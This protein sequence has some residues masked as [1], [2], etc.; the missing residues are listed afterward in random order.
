MVHTE[1]SKKK[2]RSLSYQLTDSSHVHHTETLWVNKNTQN[3]VPQNLRR[4]CKSGSNPDLDRLNPSLHLSPIR[5]CFTSEPS[6]H[7]DAFTNTLTLNGR[8][9]LSAPGCHGKPHGCPFPP[10]ILL[11]AS[12][13]WIPAGSSFFQQLS[14]ALCTRWGGIVWRGEDRLSLFSTHISGAGRQV[15]SQEP[16]GLFPESLG[17]TMTCLSCLQSTPLPP[18]HYKTVSG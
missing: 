1:L 14:P 7:G 8:S 9:D 5:R 2:K 13:L 10:T 6:L 17:S 15:S 4:S 3:P 12:L 11:A 16:T 18:I